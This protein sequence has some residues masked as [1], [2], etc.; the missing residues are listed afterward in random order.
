[1]FQHIGSCSISYSFCNRRLKTYICNALDFDYLPLYFTFCSS[2]PLL[3][4]NPIILQLCFIYIISSSFIDNSFCI[5]PYYE[6]I[7]LRQDMHCIDI[8]LLIGLPSLLSHTLFL[9]ENGFSILALPSL[10]NFVLAAS[11]S[12]VVPNIF[13]PQALYVT[14]FLSFATLFIGYL[15]S[16][17]D[18]KLHDIIKSLQEDLF[19]RWVKEEGLQDWHIE[20]RS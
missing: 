19:E 12:Y 7:T 9:H 3:R 11:L 18:N 10:F 6:R 8:Y 4:S 15:G 16:H 2:F 14:I 20:G 5:I 17:T 1:M 13:V